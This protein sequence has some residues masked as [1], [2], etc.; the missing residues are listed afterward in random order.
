MR[1][2]TS[3]VF[4]HLDITYPMDLYQSVAYRKRILREAVLKKYK[5]VLV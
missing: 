1:D 2:L 5:A 3:G 4:D